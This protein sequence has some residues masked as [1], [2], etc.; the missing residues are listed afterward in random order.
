MDVIM[1]DP[2]RERI[3]IIG[4]RG[5]PACVGPATSRGY[6]DD[7]AANEELFTHDGWMLMGD[8]VEIDDEN[9]LRVVGRVGDFIIRGGK[10]ISA[11]AVEAEVATHPSIALVA[12]VADPDVVLGERV[13][14]F[15]TL[16][17]G[18]TLTLDELVLYLRD[19]G[20]SKDSL[21]ERLTILD[22]LPISSGGKIAKGELRLRAKPM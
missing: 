14:L 8:L 5:Q 9:Y 16:I 10:N 18:A 2:Q 22:E 11:T 15:A 12:A 13:G 21:P 20:M 17:P 4:T 6:W 7:A 3:E 1:L 19:R